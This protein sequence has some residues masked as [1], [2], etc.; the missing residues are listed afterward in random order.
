MTPGGDFS[1]LGPSSSLWSPVALL[2]ALTSRK[3][4]EGQQVRDLS[5]PGFW[6]EGCVRAL[7]F[8]LRDRNGLPNVPQ[9]LGVELVI[10][11][12][13]LGLDWSELGKGPSVEE[14]RA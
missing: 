14:D 5:P 11:C 13:V 4:P 10:G 12:W 3:G 1:L 7:L 9:E 8:Q 2:C 6:L